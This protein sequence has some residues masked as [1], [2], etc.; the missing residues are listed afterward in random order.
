MKSVLV[1]EDDPDVLVLV[2][3]WLEREGYAVAHAADG[4]AALITLAQEPLP[5]LVLLDVMLP[6]LDGFAVLTRLRAD[7]RTRA[8]PVIMVTSFTRD[9]DVARGRKLGANDYIVKPL[10]EVDFL[11]RVEKALKGA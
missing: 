5:D 2:Q 4:N 10:A 9:K 6:K 8:L 1:V 11:E 7:A 3:R